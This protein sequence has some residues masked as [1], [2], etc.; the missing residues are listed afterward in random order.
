[1][2]KIVP[3]LLIMLIVWP[4]ISSA[5]RFRVN[6]LGE[7]E[8]RK[9]IDKLRVHHIKFQKLLE[10]RVR[11]DSWEVN[12]KKTDD[13]LSKEMGVYIKDSKKVK[14]GL[15]KKVDFAKKWK[16]SG[17][18][19]KKKLA[20]KAFRVEI[21]KYNKFRAGYNSLAMELS[22]FLAKRDPKDIKVLMNGMQELVS[23]LEKAIETKDFSKA[24]LIANNSKI[25]S[26]FGFTKK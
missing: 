22:S 6:T 5:E 2:K 10:M 21:G 12:L 7:Q 14:K 9:L 17:R 4:A 15:M 24:K 3:L 19:E 26:E 8:A 23:N 20:I 1:M 13:T 18:H 11:V 25:A 16:N